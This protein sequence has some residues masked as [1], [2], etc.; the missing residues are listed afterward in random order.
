[1]TEL[2]LDLSN[3]PTGSKSELASGIEMPL[4]EG[5]K[6]QTVYTKYESL[7]TMLSDTFHRE[8]WIEEATIPPS[9]RSGKPRIFAGGRDGTEGINVDDGRIFRFNGHLRGVVGIMNEEEADDMEEAT[10]EE[11]PRY[12]AWD[13]KVSSVKIT[14]GPE[15]RHN[16]QKAPDDQRQE[17]FAQMAAAIKEAFVSVQGPS[18]DVNQLAPTAQSLV[19][20]SEDQLQAALEVKRAAEDEE[21]MAAAV[22]RVG[23][24]V[25]T[26]PPITL[27]GVDMDEVKPSRGRK[28]KK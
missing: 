14:N 5:F 23:E 18:L 12:H 24:D 13:F 26:D 1:M 20:M 21:E 10:D 11:V 8:P 3:K 7:D 15:L 25:T 4:G 6:N 9:R 17:E 2:T 28:T 27:V 22:N 16:L 19:D